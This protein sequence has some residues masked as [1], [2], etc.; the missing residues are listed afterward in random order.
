MNK[1][2][3]GVLL[4]AVLSTMLGPIAAQAD[5]PCAWVEYNLPGAGSDQV[6]PCSPVNRPSG[7]DGQN[8]TKVR[9]PIIGAYYLEVGVRVPLP[10][11]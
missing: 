3:A 8:T 10:P 6:P 9:Q 4:A 1:R 11:G 7:W 5:L 2:L